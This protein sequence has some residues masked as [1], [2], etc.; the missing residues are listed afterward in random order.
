LVAL[1]GIG[2][3]LTELNAPD[4]WINDC[5][6]PAD[7]D[8]QDAELS[9]I[10]PDALQLQPDALHSP[11]L[12]SPGRTDQARWA[13]RVQMKHARHEGNDVDSIRLLEF[14]QA[15][16]YEEE[17][18]ALM[19]LGSDMAPANITRQAKA[20]DTTGYAMLGDIV[21]TTIATDT[22]SRAALLNS[23]CDC[24]GSIDL[25]SEGS[26][27]EVLTVDANRLRAK[28]KRLSSKNERE[29][30]VPLTV[31]ACSNQ[32]GDLLSSTNSDAFCEPAPAEADFR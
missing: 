7:C 16:D 31:T 23:S 25:Q 28:Y 21:D 8:F 19:D 27:H 32:H 10:Q 30:V 17:V 1:D 22:V 12:E 18:S 5:A 6:E 24:D 14:K 3:T 9:P 2:E 29:L 26:D 13:F 20:P 4:K 15:V 11:A